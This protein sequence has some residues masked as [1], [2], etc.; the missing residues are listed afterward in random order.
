MYKILGADHKEYGPVTTEQ[1]IQWITE[2][3]AD[4]N[5]HV[6]NE[7]SMD[8]KPLSA[9]PEFAAAL[10]AKASKVPPPPVDQGNAD[11]LTSQL[12][13]RDYTIDA[14]NCVGR[15]WQL[16]KE[17]FWL[18]VGASFVCGLIQGIPIAGI[19]LQ[20]VVFGGLYFMFLKLIRTR[21]AEFGDAF[22]GFSS[23]FVPLM[24]AGLVSVLLVSVGLAFCIIPGIY[25]AIAWMF[26]VPLV[27]DKRLDFWPAME[28]SRKMV[29]KH[30]WQ[31]FW[32]VVL[33]VLV[34]I[35]G[36]LVCCVGIYVAMPV[37]IAAIAYAYEDIFGAQTT[38]RS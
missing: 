35:L 34:C 10:S 38:P 25:L 1:V 20:G 16:V 15:G 14:G 7:G 11:L 33:N 19:I 24:L 21:Q 23:N 13:A 4:A 36:F 8:W 31:L 3:R 27:M 26:A 12:L 17:N 28:L 37:T 5:T 29:G 22:V 32:L 18:C 9:F 2:G 6:Q 30:W